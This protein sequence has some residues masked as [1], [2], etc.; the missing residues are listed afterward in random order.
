MLM[1]LQLSGHDV[2]QHAPPHLH[3]DRAF[4]PRLSG[5]QPDAAQSRRVVRHGQQLQF[6]HEGQPGAYGLALA[7]AWR[8]PL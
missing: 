2:T 5:G 3:Q 6:H 7:D 8:R 4:K 1:S